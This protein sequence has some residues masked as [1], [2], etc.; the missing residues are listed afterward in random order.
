MKKTKIVCSIGPASSS[1]DVLKCMVENGMNVARINFS[2]AKENEVRELVSLIKEID[3]ELTTNTGIMY[4][5]KGPDFRGSILGETI[6]LKDGEEVILTKYDLID[7]RTV[8]TVNSMEL[9]DALEVNQ[10]VFLSDGLIELKVIDKT[11]DSAICKVIKG[12][13][14]RNNKGI[15]IPNLKLKR[16]FL[17]E[18]DKIDIKLACE[19]EGDF[20][21]LSFVSCKEDILQV[22]ELLKEYNYENLMLISK[23]ESSEAFKNIDEIIDYSDGIMVARGDLGI[24]IPLVKIPSIQK[25]L[26]KKCRS[27]NKP[28]IVA[29]EMLLSMCHNSRPTRAEVVDVANAVLEGTDAVMLSEETTIGE[30]PCLTVKYMADICF[31]AEKSIDSNYIPV[32]KDITEAIAHSV[33]ETAKIIDAKLIVA[34]T[35]SGYTANI[36]SNLKPKCLVLATCPDEKVARRLSIQ[37]G[38]YSK[39]V[40]MCD[41]ID[42]I[43]E[44]SKVQA[45]KFMDLKKEDV[46]VITSGLSEKHQTNIMKI[47]QI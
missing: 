22:R 1:F 4:D 8:I 12:D 24:E 34:S 31:E 20:L 6:L 25:E 7:D 32:N 28:C 38:V 36:I 5:T 41:S 40:N 3:K 19:L 21:A 18:Q 37:W 46:I 2:H 11:N 44:E 10:S 43:I 47:G 17:S 13:Q 26:I 23:V 9:I 27:K 39:V 30:N 33:V 15:N 16:E 29:T 35:I 45:K 42:A 14:L